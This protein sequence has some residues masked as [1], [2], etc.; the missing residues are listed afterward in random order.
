VNG[1]NTDGQKAD[2]GRSPGHKYDRTVVICTALEVEYGAVREFVT[3]PLSTHHDRGT[4]YEKGSFTAPGGGWTVVLVETGA[5]N[6]TA[7]VAL[8]RAITKFS[9]DVVL[10]V[11]VAGGRKDVVLGDVVAADAVYDYD[12]GKDTGTGYLPRIKTHSSAHALVQCAKFVARGR[13]WQ[14]RIHVPGGRLPNAVV[15][16]LAAGSKVIAD[17]RSATAR[18]LELYCSDAAAVD[19][20]GHGFLH[21][22]YVNAGVEALVIR[23]VSD[24]LSGKSSMADLHWQPLAARHAA[25]FA[26]ELLAQHIPSTGSDTK[27]EATGRRGRFRRGA[28][29]TGVLVATL[30]ATVSAA[31]IFRP[32]FQLTSGSDGSPTPSISAMISATPTSS[33]QPSAPSSPTSPTTGTTSAT[34]QEKNPAT[35]PAAPPTRKRQTAVLTRYR[36]SRGIRLSATPA[37]DVP[38]GF[39]ADTRLGSLLTT[40]EANTVKLYACKLAGGDEHRFTS[41]DQT[42]ACEGQT[43]IALLGYEFKQAPREQYV[44]LFRCYTETGE[45]YDSVKI[46]C[47]GN[48]SYAS[49]YLLP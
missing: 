47:D 24:M 10:F 22:A 43:T 29:A 34:I 25:A 19:M 6:S 1:N 16:P 42:G 7:G 45:H 31:V 12:T 46:D 14:K 20:E 33:S 23:G 17:D 40:P 3:E 30:T 36:D 2:R 32:Q 9:P 39:V 5:G 38:E 41:N 26:F 18:H 4:I 13:E 27:A 11:G 37:I 35:P 15:R 49:G 21:G 8:E 28:W 44:P 48:Y